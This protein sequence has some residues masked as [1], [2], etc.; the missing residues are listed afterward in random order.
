MMKKIIIT[1]LVLFISANEIVLRDFEGVYKTSSSEIIVSADMLNKYVLK[2]KTQLQNFKIKYY[3]EKDNKIDI[4]IDGLIKISTALKKIQNINTDEDLAKNIIKTVISNLKNIDSEIKPYLQELITKE[5]N[6]ISEFKSKNKSK[7]R[8]FWN[9]IK[10]S[11]NK[12][13]K[14]INSKSF[15]SK[16]DKEILLHLESLS[17]YADNIRKTD[18]M[19]FDSIY[20][21]KNHLTNNIKMTILEIDKI[22]ELL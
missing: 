20:S 8:D 16:N 18:K 2:L 9:K 22:K 1:F 13:K 6:I 21:M 15:L 4:K 3:I 14:K 10:D 5:Q 12:I 17:N 19:A 11:S 7:F